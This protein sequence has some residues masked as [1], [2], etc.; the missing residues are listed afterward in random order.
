ML[1]AYR[2][3]EVN[4]HAQR[5]ELKQFAPHEWVNMAE[6]FFDKVSDSEDNVSTRYYVRVD[7]ANLLSQ[8]DFYA[9]YAP[10]KMPEQVSELPGTIVQV[11]LSLKNEDD[12]PAEYNLFEMFLAS[13]DNAKIFLYDSSLFAAYENKE[14]TEEVGGIDIIVINPGKEV[15]YSVFYT[16]NTGE[17]QKY[18]HSHIGQHLYLL[19]GLASPRLEI[20]LPSLD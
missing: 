14:V 17:D 9:Q 15:K 12:K 1:I 18:L 16:L 6:S 10:E 7:G 4:A 8:K 11:D 5:P 20:D 13:R 3:F 2:I 19:A